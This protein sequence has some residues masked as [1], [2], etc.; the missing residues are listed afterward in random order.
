[1]FVRVWRFEVR[2]EHEGDFVSANGPDGEWARLFSRAEGYLG[3]TLEPVA[4]APR[5]YRTT[6]H[7]RSAADFAAFLERFGEAYRALDARYEPWTA[8]ETMEF[9]GL[10]PAAPGES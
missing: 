5:C 1:M 8:R 3:T 4:G 7:W 10:S 9:E 6:D 2:R